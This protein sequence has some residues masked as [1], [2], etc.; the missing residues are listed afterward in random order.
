[1]PRQRGVHQAGSLQHLLA[2]LH[3]HLVCYVIVTLFVC[4]FLCVLCCVVLCRV[5]LCCVVSCR[6][7]LCRVVSC[8]VV[9]CLCAVLLYMFMWF[10]C[11]ASTPIFRNGDST[12]SS[13]I[14]ISALERPEAISIY[15]SLYMYIHI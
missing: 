9:L 7:V 4:V 14:W 2:S 6:V 11:R 8:R 15:L 12:P 1:M 3:T 10:I 5:V 13:S